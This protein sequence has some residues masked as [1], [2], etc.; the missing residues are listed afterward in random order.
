MSAAPLVP[1][2][3]AAPAVVRAR[4][5]LALVSTVGVTG[6]AVL[7]WGAWQFGAAGQAPGRYFLLIV[8]TTLLTD[9]TAIDLRV[10]RHAESFTWSELSIVLG[11]ALLPPDQLLL[12]ALALGVAYLATGQ[13]LVKWVLNVGSYAVGLGLAAWVCHAITTPD[14]DSPVRSAVALLAGVVC[15]GVWNKLTIVAAISLAQGRPLLGVLR[16]ELASSVVVF[17]CNVGLAFGCLGLALSHRVLVWVAPA[18]I[19]L[20]GVLNRCYLRLVQDRAAW[21]ELERAGRELTALDEQVLVATALTRVT[22]LMQSDGAEL[23]L[24]SG[25]Q[26]LVH[27]LRDGAL[28]RGSAGASSPAAPTVTV[29]RTD[30]SAG[31]PVECTEAAVPLE[32]PGGPLGAL[33][34][35]Y[36]GSVRLNRRERSQLTA[37]AG[38]LAVALCNARLHAQLQ[39]QADRSAH[40]AVHD[41]LTGLPNRTLLRAR[42]GEAIAAGS[43]VSVL[44]LDLDRFK[45]V[46]DTH[47]HEAGDEVLRVVAQRLRAALRPGDVVARLGGDEFAVLLRDASGTRQL[48]DRL[49]TVV[50]APVPVGDAVVTVG[51]SVGC[52]THPADGSSYEALLRAADEDMYAVK[53][54]TAA[55]EGA[56]AATSEPHPRTE[57]RSPTGGRRLVAL[58]P[59]AEAAGGEQ[60]A[61]G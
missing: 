32:S 31:L 9:V 50:A 4:A 43:E 60:S 18:C 1:S 20:A 55:L 41:G 46:N 44:L 51:A 2:A 17:C 21:R 13:P 59:S 49:R 22:A 47:G 61:V 33:V 27:R 12:T 58:R 36:D 6:S 5:L 35:Q 54:R 40:E 48:A 26:H 38:S 3:P 34:V 57:R 29:A 16:S 10:G 28:E 37:Y 25:D 15:F 14:F 53:R 39:S 11:L 24:H 56:R 23:R 7:V 52:A 45:P 8:V 42:V 19:V 30:G